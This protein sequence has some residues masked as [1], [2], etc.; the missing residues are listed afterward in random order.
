MF[1]YCSTVV[2][3]EILFKKKNWQEEDVFAEKNIQKIWYF[4]KHDS[5]EK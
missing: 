3:L 4:H 1:I 5:E 2:V